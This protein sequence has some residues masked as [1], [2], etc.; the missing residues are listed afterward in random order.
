MNT[1]LIY[2]LEDNDEDAYIVKQVLDKYEGRQK[3]KVKHFK[4][5]ANLKTAIDTVKPEAILIDLNLPE[6]G[7]LSTLTKVTHLTKSSPI[8]V[9]TGISDNIY[10]EKAIQL[11]AQDYIPKHEISTPLLS[12]TITFS[13]ERF[14]LQRNLENLVVMDN[15]TM[16]HNR[17]AFD[18]ELEKAVSDYERYGN[19]FS[20]LFIDLDNFKPVNDQLGHQ[21]GDQ[22]L[23]ILAAKLKMYKRAS[24]FVARYGGDE[25]VVIAPRLVDK[26]QLAR[27]AQHKYSLLSDTYCLQDEQG[28]LKEIH[29]DLSIGG[30]V[31]PDDAVSANELIAKADKAMYQAKSNNLPYVI[32]NSIPKEKETPKTSTLINSSKGLLR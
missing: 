25:F 18:D 9:L 16:L 32:L 13:K 15:L 11:G 23:R 26:S 7:G 28:D 5:I 20:L 6:S 29:L 24:D 8:I 21:A 27:L 30:V 4:T 17:G 12:R 19:G 10:G 31:F 2:L 1:W 14:E 22:L 3:F